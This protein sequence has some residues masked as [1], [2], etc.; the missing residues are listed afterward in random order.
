M[1]RNACVP[2]NGRSNPVGWGIANRTMTAEAGS[3]AG[4]ESYHPRRGD[5]Q[6]QEVTKN[7]AESGQQL[8][9]K[10]STRRELAATSDPAIVRG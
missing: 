6:R 5:V 9:N 8:N 4:F 10:G 7:C 3:I 1:C 2:G